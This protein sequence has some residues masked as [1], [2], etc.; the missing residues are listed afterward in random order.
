MN[1]TIKFFLDGGFF[2]YPIAIMLLLGLVVI[3]ERLYMILFVYRAHGADLMQKVQR[4]VLENNLEEAI[5]LCNGK[6]NSALHRVLKA[7]LVNADKPFDE[8]QDHVE[9]AKMAV[10]PKLQTRMSYLFTI[11]NTATLIGLLGT[12]FGLIV[13]FEAVGAV[14]GSQKQTLLS[15]G[16][17]TAMNTTAFGLLVAIPCMLVYGFLLNRINTIVDEVEHYSAHLLLMLR[18]GGEYF[19]QFNADSNAASTH[20]I[21]EKV[22]QKSFKQ[23]A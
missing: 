18:T 1:A 12:V 6:K 5:K 4:Y 23:G 14:E 11:G 15:T 7:G 19:D 16:I 17:S 22:D 9:V 21:P 13:T 20:Q 2:M 8:V 3:V 10:V